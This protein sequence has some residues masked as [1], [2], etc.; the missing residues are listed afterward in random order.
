MRTSDEDPRLGLSSKLEL[1]IGIDSDCSFLFQHFSNYWADPSWTSEEV[2]LKVYLILVA[3]IR[4]F[5]CLALNNL[6]RARESD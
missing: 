5:V 1:V 6:D 3:L 2:K 4:Y